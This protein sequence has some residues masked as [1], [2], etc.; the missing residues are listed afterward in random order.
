M[1]VRTIQALPPQ[2][3][4]VFLALDLA[5]GPGEKRERRPLRRP[6]ELGLPSGAGGPDLPDPPRV[7][8]VVAVN[9]H[10][11]DPAELLH[12]L[13]QAADV[14]QPPGGAQA[15]VALVTL[16]LE[17]V[18][19]VGVDHPPA[20]PIPITRGTRDG[21][22]GPTWGTGPPP[23]RDQGHLREPTAPVSGVRG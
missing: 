16:R 17:V 2:T 23:S 22:R 3:P 8:R 20:P 6:H 11:P 1:R 12:D 4:G 14:A 7:D 13:A 18:D 10:E 19:V 9:P 5:G 21:N 15:D